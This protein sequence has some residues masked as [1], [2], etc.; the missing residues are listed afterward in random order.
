MYKV[1]II[2][3]EEDAARIP[4]ELREDFLLHDGSIIIISGDNIPT[5]SYLDHGEPED[6]SFLRD[7]S[8]VATE[9]K[10]A[11]EKGLTD[12]ALN[13]VPADQAPYD[14]V[15]MFLTDEG[16]WVE[17]FIYDGGAKDYGYV[18]YMPLDTREV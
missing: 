2:T 4:D 7:W 10:R 6:N 13:A 5:T 1:E 18:A 3:S 17:G 9:L 14:T 8:W 15:G 12:A 11:Y 16:N